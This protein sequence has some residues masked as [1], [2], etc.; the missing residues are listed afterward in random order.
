[1]RRSL[2]ACRCGPLRMRVAAMMVP[3][4][5]QG[6]GSYQTQDA[7]GQGM[8]WDALL[9]G[10]TLGFDQAV[11]DK[12]RL[13]GLVGFAASRFSSD[14]S[15]KITTNSYFLGGYAGYDMGRIFVDATLFGGLS[16][17]TQK[18]EVLDNTIT[19]GTETVEAI[20]M[21]GSSILL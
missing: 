12:L 1:M 7:D 18:R 20:T 10:G 13:G 8:G 2:A 6:F 5:W 17:F 19:G 15:E 16:D 9:G 11:S 21:A 3:S 4:G 14:G